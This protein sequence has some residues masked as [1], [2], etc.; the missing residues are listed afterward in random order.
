MPPNAKEC[1]CP[2]PK[3]AYQR[4]SCLAACRHTWLLL[5]L[6]LP[7]AACLPLS[8]C[9]HMFVSVCLAGFMPALLTSTH[10]IAVLK[11]SLCLVP[12]CFGIRPTLHRGSDQVSEVL[13][14]SLPACLDLVLSL[15]QWSDPSSS[16]ISC[17][18]VA[19]PPMIIVCEQV[20]IL[21]FSLSTTWSQSSAILGEGL[22]DK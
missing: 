4:H 17:T 10:L 1:A 11:S 3:H 2:C 9:L 16:H 20:V 13:S 8:I 6:S 7:V 14:V 18:T 15:S 12:F 5:C 21:T 22:S 19:A